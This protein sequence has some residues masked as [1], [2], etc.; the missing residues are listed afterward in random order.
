MSECVG[1][2]DEPSTT[3]VPSATEISKPT[4]KQHTKTLSTGIIVLIIGIAGI[5]GTV[6]FIKTKK[7]KNAVVDPDGFDEVS[8]EEDREKQE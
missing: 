8:E 4:E 2:A 1:K 6:Y 3:Q 5:G 7:K